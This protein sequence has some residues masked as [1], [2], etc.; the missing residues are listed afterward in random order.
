MRAGWPDFH[1]S[2][3]SIPARRE[4]FALVIGIVEEI[5]GHRQTSGSATRGQLYIDGSIND[6][7]ARLAARLAH[8]ELV[9]A[10]EGRGTPLAVA[11]SRELSAGA[12]D[13]RRLK[14]SSASRRIAPDGGEAREPRFMERRAR[15]IKNLEERLA[16]VR[17]A[18]DRLEDQPS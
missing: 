2:D 9:D 8:V 3:S 7:I 14:E 10:L 11:W 13:A 12:G 15:V 1:E 5:R 17:E 16:A 6:S 4:E 18:L